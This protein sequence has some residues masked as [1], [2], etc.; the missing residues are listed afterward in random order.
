MDPVLMKLA[1]GGV[2]FLGCIGIL[3]GVGLALAAQKFAVEGDPK[4]EEVLEVLAGAQC[5]GCGFPGCE[6]YAEA[7]VHDP[8]VPPNLCF[9]GKAE[10]AEIVAE[11]CGKKV[12]GVANMVAQVRCSR[13]DGEVQQKYTYLGYNSCTGA[14]LAFGGP[15]ECSYACIGLGDCVASCPFGAISMENQFPEIDVEKCV[16]CGSC[17]RSCPKKVIELMPLKA[18]VW[19][20]CST[21]D[22]GKTVRSLCKV[23]CITCKMCVKAC[24]AGAVSIENDLVR[25]DHEKCLA[26]G[27]DCHEAC[28]EKC[29]RK[30]FRPFRSEGKKSG[31]LQ[32]A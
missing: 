27:P 25:I 9:P 2:A 11:I 15:Q 24:P 17:V 32:A 22:P 31:E 4:V 13:I 1:L 7:V 8:D 5:G 30:I 29:P 12:A 21:H 10:V 3:F 6:G 28:V 23:G 19:V 20:P 26:Y 14:S 16:G 18:R